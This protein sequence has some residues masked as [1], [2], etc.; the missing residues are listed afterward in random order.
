MLSGQQTAAAL[1]TVVRGMDERLDKIGHSVATL[2]ERITSLEE[3][4]DEMHDA[5]LEDETESDDDFIDDSAS[6]TDSIESSSSS[7]SGGSVASAESSSAVREPPRRRMRTRY[8][9]S[10]GGSQ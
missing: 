8:T 2:V 10:D 4:I 9:S 6:S 1:G 5:L 3:K 7:D